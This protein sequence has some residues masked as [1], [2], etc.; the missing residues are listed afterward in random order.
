MGFAVASLIC[1]IYTQMCSRF[2]KLKSNTDI[3]IAMIVADAVK[4]TQSGLCDSQSV[5]STTLF[6]LYQTN[7]HSNHR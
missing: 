6:S 1:A 3:V 4:L 2:T 5:N 7:Y